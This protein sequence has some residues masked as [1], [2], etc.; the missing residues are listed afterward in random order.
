[1]RLFTIFLYLGIYAQGKNFKTT[2]IAEDASTF[3]RSTLGVGLMLQYKW[4]FSSDILF[5]ID[6]GA[7]RNFLEKTTWDD[8]LLQGV[9]PKIGV[10]GFFRLNLG[11]RFGG[12]N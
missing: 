6:A 7:G 5:E 12:G 1:M 11:Y 9:L 2:A 4:V 3:K 8:D 10:N